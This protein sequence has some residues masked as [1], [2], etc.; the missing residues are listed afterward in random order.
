M[1][2]WRRIL[3]SAVAVLVVAEAVY[4]DLMPVCEPA[5][6]CTETVCYCSQPAC[7]EAR[8]SGL[9]DG[10]FCLFGLT[11]SPTEAWPDPKAGAAEA[12]EPE[13]YQVLT[14]GSTSFDL[15]LY[16]LIGLG[17]CRSGHWVRRP[18]LG[19]VP[20]W[21]HHGGPF[22]IGHSQA[23][24]PGSLC[25]VLVCCFIQADRTGQDHV[26]QYRLGRVLALGRKLQCTP[27]VIASRAPPPS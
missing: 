5:T 6:V 4:A 20:E 17:L 12:S 8:S 18:S 16:A 3:V 9:F 22:Q 21:Y 25:P 10:R 2:A 1:L 11:A 19:F 26:S 15:C 7:R 24:M 13:H 27:D 23:L 14:D